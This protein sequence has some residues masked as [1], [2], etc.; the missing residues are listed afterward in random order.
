LVNKNP[1]GSAAGYGSSFPINRKLTTTLLGFDDLHYNSVYAQMMRGKTE[2]IVAQAIANVAA[3]L[4]KL[5]MD[6][7]L[8]VNQ[9]FDFIS[10]PSALTT[11]SS[12]MPHKKNP[13]AFELIRAKCND[14]QGLP[15]QII[16]LTNNLPS[17]YHRDFQLL[18]EKIL[19]AFGTINS[20]LEMMHFM[21]SN[22]TVKTNLLADDKY[23]YIF[24]VEEVNR[25]VVTG[26]PFRDA[27]QQVGLAIENGTFNYS[28][29]LHHTH[30]G[31][32]GN[33]CLDRIKSNFESIKFLFPFEKITRAIDSLVE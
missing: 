28:G 21:L 13:D 16:L 9:N 26:V 14:L 11:G 33:L 25:L 29:S 12:I 23:K 6:I 20:C 32:I 18:K 5:A 27:Y 7:C 30:E 15:N 19:P 2:R 4:S 8:F 22:I 10:F 31:S 17:G 24:S 1:L 3:T